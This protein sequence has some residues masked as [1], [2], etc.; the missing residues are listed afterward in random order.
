MLDFFDEEDYLEFKMDA[1]QRLEGSE[2]LVLAAEKDKSFE[3]G[4][5]ELV[6]NFHTLKGNAMILGI[7]EM[8]ELLHTIE[9]LLC[10]IRDNKPIRCGLEQIV[11]LLLQN[12]DYLKD[13]VEHQD[14][15]LDAGIIKKQQLAIRR[16]LR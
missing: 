5:E 6:R 15:K 11:E 3:K 4:L 7:N 8:A 10:A 9:D 13:A 12:I 2:N 1:L 16:I 14:M